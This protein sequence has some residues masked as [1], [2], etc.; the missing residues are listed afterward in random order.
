MTR[1][2]QL[3]EDVAAA[4]AAYLFLALPELLQLP[5]SELH[6]RLTEQFQTAICACF[7]FA[8]DT[9]VA[10]KLPMPAEG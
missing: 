1:Q 10:I 8:H 2:P 7:E 9:D 3:A 6:A 4:S 5:A